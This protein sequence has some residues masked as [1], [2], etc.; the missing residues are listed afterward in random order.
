MRPIG[1]RP[2]DPI[3]RRA[4]QGS[5]RDTQ[6]HDADRALADDRR[7]LRMSLPGLPVDALPKPITVKIDF[8]AGVIDQ[9]IERL[10]VLRAKMLP[11]PPPA[12][13]RN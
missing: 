11:K 9:M 4:R 6:G 13:K 8:D 7:S 2:L 3:D 12:R 5:G 1:R 10:T